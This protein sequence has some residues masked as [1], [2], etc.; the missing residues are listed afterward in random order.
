MT[1]AKFACLVATVTLAACA[2]SPEPRHAACPLI[3]EISANPPYLDLESNEQAADAIRQLRQ[4]APPELLPE[5]EALAP[6]NAEMSSVYADLLATT[7]G[8]PLSGAD[9]ELDFSK[10][11]A[12]QAD[13]QFAEL[14]Q[15]RLGIVAALM[16]WKDDHC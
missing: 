16:Q 4:V 5:V 9:G 3:A 7:E 12:I 10:L 13:P 1:S 11:E 15:Q 14:A 2:S 6:I 8:E